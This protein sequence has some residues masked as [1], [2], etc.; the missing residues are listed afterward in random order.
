MDTVMAPGVF[1]VE[2][3][4]AELLRVGPKLLEGSWK[5]V[6]QDLLAPLDEFEPLL[7]S[8]LDVPMLVLAERIQLWVAN[9]QHGFFCTALTEIMQYPQA[10]VCRIIWLGG[11]R[12]V[13]CLFMAEALERW[14][15]QQ[16]A[17]YIEATGRDGWVRVASKIGY[18]EK[19]TYIMKS[20][21]NGKAH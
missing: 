7:I 12:L 17:K 2:G 4:V 20:L 1:S 19:G 6:L 5:A 10:T 9:D 14:A 18:E 15:I 3:R 11:R 21:S 8:S 16:G 13:D